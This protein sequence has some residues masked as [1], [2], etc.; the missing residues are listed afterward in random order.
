MCEL[1]NRESEFDYAYPELPSGADGG[2]HGA[3]CGLSGMAACLPDAPAAKTGV[4]SAASSAP[5]VGGWVG[6]GGPLPRLGHSAHVL[7]CDCKH[8]HVS[9]KYRFS[10]DELAPCWE[11]HGWQQGL[12]VS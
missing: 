4:N 11:F 6:L 5:P 8:N 12:L 1:G 7:N 9:I 3:A 2:V 10:Y